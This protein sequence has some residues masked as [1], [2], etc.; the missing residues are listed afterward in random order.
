GINGKVKK[1]T[2]PPCDSRAPMRSASD[3][4][5]EIMI[6]PCF[7]VSKKIIIND[8]FDITSDLYSFKFKQYLF[9]TKS[10]ISVYF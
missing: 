3:S 6:S 10:F 9:Y 1:H 7:G 4:S 8:I 2:L 5:P